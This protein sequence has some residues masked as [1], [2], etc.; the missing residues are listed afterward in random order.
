MLPARTLQAQF[1]LGLGVVTILNDYC[2]RRAFAESAVCTPSR[3]AAGLR[4]FFGLWNFAGG[5]R[6]KRDPCAGND[7]SLAT[8]E[9][10]GPI[11][12]RHFGQAADLVASGP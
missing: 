4:L 1:L 3:R 7:R 2:K 12:G 11:R 8:G 10:V 6:A 5:I 9:D